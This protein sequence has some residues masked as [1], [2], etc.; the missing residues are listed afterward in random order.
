M[1]WSYTVHGPGKSTDRVLNHIQKELD[2]IRQDPDDLTEWID[3]IILA[4]NG[5][6][7]RGFTPEQIE[8]ELH[9][10]LAKNKARQWPDYTTVPTN[11][12]L[13]ALD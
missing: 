10:K 3:V 6:S 13:E 5:A 11:Q 4:L 7:R 1:A 9:S 8:Q 2:E 12:P